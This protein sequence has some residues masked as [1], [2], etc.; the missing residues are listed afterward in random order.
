MKHSKQLE[1]KADRIIIYLS[2]DFCDLP[3]KIQNIA[4]S[5]ILYNHKLCYTCSYNNEKILIKR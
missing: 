1:A 2:N 5:R 3:E 4:E